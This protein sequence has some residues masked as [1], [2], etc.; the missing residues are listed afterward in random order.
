MRTGGGA[1]ATGEATSASQYG[2]APAIR[3]WEY[4]V[5]FGQTGLLPEHRGGE[6]T[7]SAGPGPSLGEDAAAERYG[8]LRDA[9]SAT[10]RS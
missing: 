1:S 9:E 2:R 3:G 5:W 10:V 8:R 6:W 4:P 7:P